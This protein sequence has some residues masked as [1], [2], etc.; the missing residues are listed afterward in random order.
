V[1]PGRDATNYP[2]RFDADL[3]RI[4]RVRVTMRVQAALS[5]LRGPAGVLFTHAARRRAPNGWCPIR[6]FSSRYAR[7]MTLGR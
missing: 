4:R 3:L 7:N 1:V 6:K 5:A 2:N